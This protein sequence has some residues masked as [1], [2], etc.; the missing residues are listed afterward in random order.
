MCS[1][2]FLAR[3]QM[4]VVIIVVAVISVNVDAQ[5]VRIDVLFQLLDATHFAVS[6]T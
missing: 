2:T 4:G 5:V 3:F 6:S 1:K